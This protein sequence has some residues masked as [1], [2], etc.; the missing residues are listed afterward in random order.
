M[1]QW[2]GLQIT[3]EHVFRSAVG[4]P[5][6]WDDEP[7]KMM[8]KPFG[9][10]SLGQC[11]SVGRDAG[12]YRFR[13]G[14]ANIDLVGHRELTINVQVF[15]RHAHGESS[16]RFLIEKARLS[17][18]NPVYR[19]EL[20]SAGLIFVEN[21]PVTSLNF[22]FQNRAENRAAFDVVFRLIMQESAPINT[23]YFDS[24]ELENRL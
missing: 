23:A 4:I 3:L 16:A 9:I 12:Y 22:S 11:I 2:P 15:S 7:R 20:R 17:F 6:V 24:L 10:L 19:D 13:D 1:K 21:H 18:A 14:G 5:F 8:R